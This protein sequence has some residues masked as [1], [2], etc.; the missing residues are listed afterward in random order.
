MDGHFDKNTHTYLN[1]HFALLV[2]NPKSH[3][4]KRQFD[5]DAPIRL[6]HPSD[7]NLPGTTKLQPAF[8][9][10]AVPILEQNR[11]LPFKSHSG[12]QY[13]WSRFPA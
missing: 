7:T 5:T 13:K 4:K 9:P 12:R 8:R 11:I 6:F 3:R 10:W 2:S 1:V